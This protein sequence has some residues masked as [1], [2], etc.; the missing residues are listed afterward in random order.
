VLAG[1]RKG[2]PFQVRD[3]DVPAKIFSGRVT[4]PATVQ[5]FLNAVGPE[6]GSA[7]ARDYLVSDLRRP[8][9]GIITPDGLLD[10]DKFARWQARRGETIKM[11]PGLGDEFA[12]L[13]TAQRALDDVQAAHTAALDEYRSGVAKNFLNEEPARAV[14]KTLRSQDRV[15]LM[16]DIIT[17]VQ[18]NPDALASLRGHVIDYIIDNFTTLAK[19][20]DEVG[21]FRPQATREFVAE[22]KGWLRR[23]MGGQ[24]MQR[25]EQV[26][27][28]LK[29][30][31]IKGLAT[32]G[33]ATAERAMA[34]AKQG[35]FRQHIPSVLG[36]LG[37]LIA[38]KTATA[39]GVP[40]AVALGSEVLAGSAPLLVHSFRQ[41]GIQTIND[42]VREAM[43]HPEVARELMVRP[44]GE[45]IG[46]ILQRRVGRAMQG[47]IA[48][49][50]ASDAKQ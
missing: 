6:R 26:A 13:E 3:A 44:K 22:N 11:F 12:S 17:R 31:D 47:V 48:A 40:G 25:I 39:M 38:E 30:Q 45:T 23:L 18:G 8:G 33:S 1:G 37:V 20:G 32:T 24:G 21:A 42:L 28:E 7:L 46:G 27:A 16:D 36:M 35:A 2:A 41:R 49:E 4:E 5:E 43:L 19:A 29:N 14:E 10:A 50:S 15:K 34:Q 9:N